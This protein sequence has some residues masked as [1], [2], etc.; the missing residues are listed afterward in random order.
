MVTATR[1][2]VGSSRLRECMK[3]REVRAVDVIRWLYIEKDITVSSAQ[4]SQMTSGSRSIPVYLAFFIAD[5]LDV[6]AD[7]LLGK[8][9]FKTN[10]YKEFM[11]WNIDYL[12]R[13]T[14]TGRQA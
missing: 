12:R 14:A 10:S 1:R 13:H 6:D 4:M 7:Y 9:S 8:D 5:Y 3:M 11:R 2:I